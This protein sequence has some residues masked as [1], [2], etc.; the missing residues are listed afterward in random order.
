MLILCAGGKVKKTLLLSSFVLLLLVP[1][2][3]MNR[4]VLKCGNIFSYK[5]N[6]I[7]MVELRNIMKH[8]ASNVLEIKWYSFSSSV[9]VS[10]SAVYERMGSRLS[11]Y[12]NGLYFGKEVHGVMVS[13]N[14]SGKDISD[15]INNKSPKSCGRYDSCFYEFLR[16]MQKRKDHEK[17]KN[18]KNAK[19]MNR[20]CIGRSPL[21]RH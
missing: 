8:D 11:F 21:C 3:G 18:P 19:I 14:V 7:P 12:E 13:G 5:N 10:C 20:Y 15:F 17:K 6:K 2:W 1:C 9:D 4:K 16:L